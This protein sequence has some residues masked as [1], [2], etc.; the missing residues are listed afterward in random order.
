[1]C[2]EYNIYYLYELGLQIKYSL[3]IYECNLT[4]QCNTLPIHWR[5]E[6]VLNNNKPSYNYINKEPR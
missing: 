1:M 3:Y 6:R 2:C 5:L 4:L